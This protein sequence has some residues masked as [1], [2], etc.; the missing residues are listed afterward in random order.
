M[1][2]FNFIRPDKVVVIEEASKYGKYQ[3]APLEPGFGITIGNMFRRVL[4]SS[5][6]GYAVTRLK[7]S[8]VAH[9]FSTIEGVVED[10][11][12]VVLNL[13]KIRFKVK[14][15][16]THEEKITIVL[17]SG[18]EKKI[19][20][21][22]E[23]EKNS[24]LF[25]IANPDQILFTANEGVKV[26]LEL[27]VQKGRGYMTAE[28]IKQSSHEEESEIG[29]IF[30]DATFSPILNVKYS[31]ED[32]RVEQKTDY[33]KLVFEIITDGTIDT[34]DAIRDAAVLLTEHLVLF[35]SKEIKPEVRVED[36]IDQFDE[37][38]AKV[39]QL[40]NMKLVDFDL[41]VRA[42]NCLRSSNIETVGELIQH[43]RSSLMRFRNFGKKSLVEIENLLE[44][45]GLSL[46]MDISIYQK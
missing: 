18:K 2:L 28:E 21:A 17:N 23:I 35:S 41:S 3:L 1:N 8:G 14:D 42:I 38:T 30:T 37:K 36:R 25:D 32:F 45:K 19:F 29:T 9:E 20:T 13:K 16:A 10:V 39:K 43:K 27:L 46:G 34:Q 6:C 33:E 26:E 5:L 7:V 24:T 15:E 12:E 22:A 44:S 31:I 11:T 4:L 40:L